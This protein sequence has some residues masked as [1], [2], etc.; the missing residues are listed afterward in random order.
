MQSLIVNMISDV[1]ATVAEAQ[2]KATKTATTKQCK[3][4]D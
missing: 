3:N 2:K 1:L 4:G